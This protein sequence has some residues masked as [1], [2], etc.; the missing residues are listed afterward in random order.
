MT[1]V[2]I[3]QFARGHVWHVLCASAAVWIVSGLVQRLPNDYGVDLGALNPFVHLNPFGFFDPLGCQFV[4]ITGLALGT[5]QVRIDQ[6]PHWV[7]RSLLA[8]FS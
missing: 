5:A 2:L 1:P 6:I 7:Q 8:A 4:F 3:C